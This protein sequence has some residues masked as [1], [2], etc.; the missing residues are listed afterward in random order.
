MKTAASFTLLNL[1]IMFGCNI[2]SGI[3][4]DVKA[5]IVDQQ[6]PE[7][8][9][10]SLIVD[11]MGRPVITYSNSLARGLRL[12]T[13]DHGS[14]GSQVVDQDNVGQYSSLVEIADT[15]HIAYY[16]SPNGALKYAGNL[17]RTWEGEFEV[18]DSGGDVGSYAHIEMQNEQLMIT[19]QD[20]QANKIKIASGQSRQWSIQTIDAANANGFHTLVRDANGRES[21]LYYDFL[22][23]ALKCFGWP[24]EHWISRIQHVHS[25]GELSS[26]KIDSRG[27]VLIVHLNANGF[28]FFS[29]VRGEESVTE[30]VDIGRKAGKVSLVNTHDAYGVAYY[31]EA[32][33]SLAW[34]QRDARFR[35]A[36]K[37]YLPE[38]IPWSKNLILITHGYVSDVDTWVSTMARD[39]FKQLEIREQNEDWDILAFDWRLDAI[40][41]LTPLVAETAKKIGESTGQ[42]IHESGYTTAHLIGHSAGCWLV[43]ALT[44]QLG[45]PET[46]NIT[47]HETFLDAYV[48]DT[49]DQKNLGKS[50]NWAEQYFDRDI[51]NTSEI[52]SNAHN[53]DVSDYNLGHSVAGHIWPHEWY[54]QTIQRPNDPYFQSWGYVASREFGEELRSF[55]EYSRGGLTELRPVRLKPIYVPNGSFSDGTF[56]HWTIEGPGKAEIVQFSEEMYNAALLTTGSPVSLS[57]VIDTPA[58]V[59]NCEFKYRFVDSTG[60]L[61]IRVGESLV[62]TISAPAEEEEERLFQADIPVFDPALQGRERV[63]FSLLFDGPSDSHLLVTDFREFSVQLA[64]LFRRGDTNNDDQINISDAITLLSALFVDNRPLPCES[65]ADSTDDGVLN[66]SDAIRILSFLFIGGSQIPEPSG[67][68]G[69]ERTED[70]LSCE[71][72]VPCSG[73]R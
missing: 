2:A 46:R 42:L 26:L 9:G 68:C 37:N 64:P 5:E 43:S 63:S 71:S 16:D 69:F 22:E 3:D 70:T 45:K 8:N 28:P 57:R 29:V 11:P 51:P 21:L 27:K 53:I 66:I 30:E 38:K 18:V 49:L 7:N 55:D 50:A 36:S 60:C 33:T 10:C 31:D 61:E 47:I 56:D 59:F 13:K 40:D 14:W 34:A 52:L 24:E 32:R 48:P 25:G 65:A 23:S 39:I 35:I 4:W 41:L 20:S 72:T 73:K 17:R 1:A 6:I 12:A 58:A 15:L 54:S 67:N 44:D 62:A 19:Y